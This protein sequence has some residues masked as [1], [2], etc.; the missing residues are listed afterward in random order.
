MI[1]EKIKALLADEDF[2]KE[3]RQVKSIA[4]AQE[5]AKSKGL[6]LAPEQIKELIEKYAPKGEISD[7]ALDKVAGGSNGEG[8]FGDQL[9]F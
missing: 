4:G 7:D 2:M 9:T 8:F 6:D 1:E 5:L 3:L